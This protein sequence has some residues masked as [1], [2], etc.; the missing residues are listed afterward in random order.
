MAWGQEPV[1]L[2]L[3]QAIETALKQNLTVREQQILVEQAK[4]GVLQNSGEFDPALKLEYHRTYSR[5]ATFTPLISP[6]EETTGYSASVGG[7]APTGTAYELKYTSQKVEQSEDTL[8]LVQNPYYT[9]D[10]T[11]T[12]RQPLLKGLGPEVQKAQ[13]ASAGKSLDAAQHA[14]S[15]KAADIIVQTTEAYWDLYFALMNFDVAEQSLNLAESLLDEVNNK[16]QAGVLPKVELFNAEAEVALREE[17][18]LQAQKAVR[19][20]EDVLRALMDT[21]EWGLALMPVNAPIYPLAEPS[22]EESM[23]SAMVKR[24]DYLQAQ[25]DLEAKEILEKF[26]K[27]QKLPSLDLVAGAGV[28]GLGEDA[29]EAYNEAESGDYYS[30]QVGLELSVPLGNRTARGSFIRSHSE[31]EAARLRVEQVE[32]TMALEIREAMRS[33]GLSRQSIEATG[34]TKAAMEKRLEAAR[35]RFRLGMT[36]LNDV[37]KFEKEYA[38]SVSNEVRAITD[39]VKAYVRLERASGTLST[40]L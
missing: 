37:L 31:A 11:L 17:R 29:S 25:S 8:F 13:V 12:I 22:F 14:A 38:E 30:W 15:S 23:S 6:V 2:S 5:E 16:I 1:E 20:A 32:K 36:T 18:L 34:R 27:N 28:N 3:Q 21:E 19:D 10:L 26:Y 7:K 33:V 9:A 24:W 40:G 35:E 4:A 39:Y